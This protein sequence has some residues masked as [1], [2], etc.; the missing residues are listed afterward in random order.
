MSVGS[1][2]RIAD[3]YFD[4]QHRHLGKHRR[5]PSRFKGVPRQ[6]EAPGG[7]LISAVSRVAHAH[8]RPVASTTACAKSQAPYHPVTLKPHVMLAA[9]QHIQHGNASLSQ[10]TEE[11]L[12]VLKHA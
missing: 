11:R 8:S 1:W 2:V 10:Q 4:D 9:L 3:N 7:L 12:M 5:E 6:A